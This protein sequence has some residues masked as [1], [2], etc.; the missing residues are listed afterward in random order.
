MQV[1]TLD[2]HAVFN[3]GEQIATQIA[4]AVKQAHAKQMDIL[5]IICGK[6]SGALRRSVLQH[7]ERPHIS[8]CYHRLE[9]DPQ[10][11]GKIVL[12]FA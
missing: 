7:L 9:I 4:A 6:G 1:H 11:S 8:K 10:N 2:L 12:Y 5:E 3:N